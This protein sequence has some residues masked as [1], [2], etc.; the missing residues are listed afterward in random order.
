VDWEQTASALRFVIWS[1]LNG[2]SLVQE[3]NFVRLPDRVQA[4]AFKQIT[5]VRDPQGK[6]LG[7]GLLS[8]IHPPS[9]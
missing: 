8:S 9:P 3:N 7:M 6:T 5:A 1:F 4:S 2:D